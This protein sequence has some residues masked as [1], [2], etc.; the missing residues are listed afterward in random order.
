M[1]LLIH[2]PFKFE[3]SGSRVIF[4]DPEEDFTEQAQL[5]EERAKDVQQTNPAATPSQPTSG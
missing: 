4:F 5:W 3:F 1:R 2:V